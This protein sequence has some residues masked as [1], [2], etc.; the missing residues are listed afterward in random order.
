MRMDQTQ[1]PGDTG[2][3]TPKTWYP[4]LKQYKGTKYYREV[5]KDCGAFAQWVK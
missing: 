5:I 4:I 2:L 1:A 3:P